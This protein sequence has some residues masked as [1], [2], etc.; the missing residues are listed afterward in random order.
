MNE[1]TLIADVWSDE[2]SLIKYNFV[3]WEA[4]FARSIEVCWED[5]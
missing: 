2:F 3:K 4:W 1:D 5:E